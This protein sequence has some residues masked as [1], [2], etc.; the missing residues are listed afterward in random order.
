MASA[1]TPRRWPPISA[2]FSPQARSPPDGPRKGHHAMTSATGIKRALERADRLVT[3][4]PQRGQRTY[5]NRAV[6]TDGTMCKV[7]EKGFA[8]LTDVGRG[9][10]G[11]DDSPT[12]G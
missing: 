10:G 1:T 5:Q 4:S 2:A 6:I 12:P 3:D 8:L 9:L 7:E 11:G